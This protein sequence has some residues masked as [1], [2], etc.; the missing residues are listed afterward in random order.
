LAAS[1]PE[2]LFFRGESEM[3]DTVPEVQ[4]DVFCTCPQSSM[5]LR[6]KYVDE[7]IAV[8]RWSEEC[9]CRG[10]LVYTDNSLLDPW[11]VSQV[12]LQNTKKICP[13]VAVQPAYMH[14]YAVAK[15]VSSLAHLHER[16]IYLNMVAGGF[17]TDLAALNDTTRHDKRYGRLLEYTSIIKQLLGSSDPVT[18]EG[19]F[20]TVRNLKM[21]PPLPAPLLP[22]IFVSGSS[23]AGLLAAKT[24]GATAVKYPKP[25]KDYGRTN[26]QDDLGLGVRVGIIT[27]ASADEA[28]RIAHQRFP[29]DKKG[30][31]THKLAMKVSD[32]SWHKQL[33]ELANQSNVHETPYWLVPFENYKTF[34]P[35][36]VGDYGTVSDE[37]ALYVAAGYETFILD[38]P[39]NQEELSHTGEV[40]KLAARKAPARKLPAQHA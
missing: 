26:S 38:I 40:F 39:A 24:L 21:T 27:R 1:F 36:L 15:M 7:V 2:R 35:Y 13:L 3:L 17:T 25:A 28:W 11:L 23:E 5:V 10:I 19:E 20:Y 6:E 31:L 22:G 37:L 30:Q 33:S 14:P 12:I 34:C 4:L 18:F 29:S 32:S 16:R 9:G 8:A